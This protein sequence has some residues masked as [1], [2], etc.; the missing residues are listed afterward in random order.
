MKT[1]IL[2]LLTGVAAAGL[3]LA[4]LVAR[5]SSVLEAESVATAA[6]AIYRVEADTGALK[7]V[8]EPRGAQGAR[9]ASF[10]SSKGRIFTLERSDTG[11]AWLVFSDT[12]EVIP[13]TEQLGRGGDIVF[14]R[15]DGMLTLRLTARG[16]AIFYPAGDGMGEPADTLALAEDVIGAPG[17]KPA[18]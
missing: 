16:N 15:E 4:G 17:L 3:A 14:A 11:R 7:R 13:L 2:T 1:F 9:M 18:G 8:T 12:G 6:P 10:S 5:G